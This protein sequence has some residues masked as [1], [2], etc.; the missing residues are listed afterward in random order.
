MAIG[1]DPATGALL[2]V[3]IV[4]FFFGLALVLA[5]R[6]TWYARYRAA[7]PGPLKATA[8]VRRPRT[9]LPTGSVIKTRIVVHTSAQARPG[10][11]EPVRAPAE[12]ATP[13]DHDG[14][15]S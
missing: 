13:H 12:V 7:P 2:W 8:L 9:T 3:G 10:S 4:L 5:A 6:P 1:G 11:E 14:S 15:G